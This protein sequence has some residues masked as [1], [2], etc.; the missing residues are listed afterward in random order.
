MHCLK[1]VHVCTCVPSCSHVCTG[2]CTVLL[3]KWTCSC[4]YVPTCAPICACM[5]PC[6]ML[7]ARAP[8][9]MHV[10][11]W[12]VLCT[13]SHVHTCVLMACS[14]HVLPCAC[15]CPHGLLSALVPYAC[16]CPQGILHHVPM[17]MHV[18]PSAPCSHMHAVSAMIVPAAV[19]FWGSNFNN[20]FLKHFHCTFQRT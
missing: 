17:C 2:V 11:S 9:C 15:M 3:C 12:H 19:A 10:S 13:C 16:T 6:G 5:C 18:F 4:A 1:K 8:M 7:S 14:Q 20:T